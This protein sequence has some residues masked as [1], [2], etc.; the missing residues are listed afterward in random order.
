VVERSVAA[1]RL[2]H[3]LQRLAE[4]AGLSGREL[5][6]RLGI[7][8]PTISRTTR[9]EAP[10]RLP[11]VASWLQEC[12]ADDATRN[13]VLALAETALAETRPWRVLMQDRGHLQDVVRDQDA[14][15]RL[16][17]NFAPTVMPGMLQTAA[18]ARAVLGMGA[19]TDVAAAVA[20]RLRRQELLHEDARTFRFLLA[21]RV[22]RWE[23]RPGALVG[24][25]DRI[26]SLATLD[27][28]DV[29]VLR[30]DVPLDVVPWHNF[31]IRHPVEGEGPFVSTE[32]QHGAQHVTDAESVQL[33]ESV[34]RRLWEAAEPIDVARTRASD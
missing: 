21:E 19:T 32:L 3:E 15:A 2:G 23:P 27:H 14:A 12:D 13:R 9:G 11:L 17:L 25:L 26:R 24:A 28:V 1:R 33:Y 18:Y 8:Q 30:D 6:R 22:L 31:V 7:S 20:A 34:W 16:I 4:L 5:S 10:V 29:A